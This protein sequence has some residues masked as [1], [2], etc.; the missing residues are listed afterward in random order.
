MVPMPE[1]ITGFKEIEDHHKEENK[2][3]ETMVKTLNIEG[4]MCAHCQAHVKKALEG[5]A[6]VTQVE[7]SL[8]DKTATV[9]LTPG[10]E[11]QALVSIADFFFLCYAI[12][13]QKFQFTL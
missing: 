3:A 9:S 2:M 4:M 1:F 8:E 11:E 6:G 10:T 7:V 5:V 13:S 12:V